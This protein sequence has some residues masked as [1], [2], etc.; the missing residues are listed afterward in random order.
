MDDL[1]VTPMYTISSITLLNGF[2][3]VDLSVL[4]EKVVL[5]GIDEMNVHKKKKTTTKRV[6]GKIIFALKL[7]KVSLDSKTVLTP[8][9]L[10]A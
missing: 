9:F 6:S 1:G 10:E 8:V 3:I 7:L 4:Q 5:L 2:N